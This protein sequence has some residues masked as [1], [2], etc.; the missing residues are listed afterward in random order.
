[1]LNRP[2]VDHPWLFDR[3]R[4]VQNSPDKHVD[5]W[6]REH[7]KSTVITYAK[8]IQDILCSHGEDATGK[9]ITV[10]IFSHTRP[11]AKGFLRQ[12]KREFEGNEVLKE[13][14]PD[15]LYRDPQKEAVKWS[16]D[17]G[18]IVKRKSNP[19]EAT[20]EAWGV[21]DGQ[22]TGKH[23]DLLVYDDVVTAESVGS[24]DM[25]EKTMRMLE[26]SYNLGSND[27]TRRFIGTRYHFNDAYKTIMSRGT[28]T[29]RIYPATVDGSVDG[30][31]VLLTP[32][33]LAEKRRDMGPY[34]FATQ[35]LQNPK[36]DETQGFLSEWLEYLEGKERGRGNV[37][38]LFDPAGGKKKGNDYTAGWAVELGFD[39]NV[40][41]L[42]M[43]RDR[44][45]LPQRAALV[46]RWHRKYKPIEVRYEKYG[47]QSDIE[48]IKT[49]QNKESYR[50][51]IIEVSGA[52][53]K[54]DRIR[55]LIPYFS[56]KRIIL[57]LYLYYTDY[58]GTIRELVNDFVEQEYKAFPVSAHD[59]M[60]DA[61]AR[62]LE[63]DYP[64]KWPEEEN[65]YIPSS[66]D[67]QD[68][69]DY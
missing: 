51:E 52:V 36:A 47:L 1:M 25:I 13:T 4:E 49:L 50:F 57:P 12:I 45:N 14:F 40:Y 34:T 18:L 33:R 10:G 61:L 63:P 43:V 59:D 69:E 11:N 66:T 6:S 42:D 3:C 54:V 17:D 38:L 19:K 39:G 32:E 26:L 24:P 62:L 68:W 37:Y 28:A 5:L 22:P 2:D 35:M 23:F 16:E 31:P 65:P 41:V 21:V 15:I 60:L 55:R 20:I 46:M 9:E 8:T 67:T 48:H 53:A 30:T 56:S 27:G 58:E 29:P 64:L 7:Y 44:L